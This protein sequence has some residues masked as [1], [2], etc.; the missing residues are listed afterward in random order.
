MIIV[1]D[2]D[3]NRQVLMNLIQAYEAEFSIITKK[4][5]D[6]GGLYPLDTPIDQHHDA[7]LLYKGDMPIGFVVKGVADGRHD[8][9]EFYIIPTKRGKRIGE[10]F[11]HEIFNRYKGAWQVRQIE[12]ASLARKFW[13]KTISEFTSNNYEETT[14]NDPYWGVVTRQVFQNS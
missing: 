5:P 8:I 14:E 12:G 11:A 3:E 13:R 7:F 10:T 6:E 2:N 4:N 9:C 1:S